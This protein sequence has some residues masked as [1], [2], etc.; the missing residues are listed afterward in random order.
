MIDW[1]LRPVDEI[2]HPP[3]S[4]SIETEFALFVFIFINDLNFLC[5]RNLTLC[6]F[7]PQPLTVHQTIS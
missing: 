2:K 6:A 4:F 1:R 3:I 5:L 7:P